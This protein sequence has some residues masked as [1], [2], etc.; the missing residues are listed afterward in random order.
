[1]KIGAFDS[2][3][4]GFSV[5]QPLLR[6]IPDLSIVYVADTAHV[7]YSGKTPE[8]LQILIRKILRFFLDSK[9]EAVIFACN[10]SSALVLPQILP[11]SFVPFFGVIEPG[12]QMALTITKGKGIG[13]AANEVT[14]KSGTFKKMIHEKNPTIPVFEQSCPELVSLVEKGETSSPKAS[15]IVKEY[16]KPLQGKIDTLILGCTHFPFLRKQFEESLPD[17]AVIDPAY[18]LAQHFMKYFNDHQGDLNSKESPKKHDLFTTA[19]SPHVEEW[20]KKVLGW[21]LTA[22]LLDLTRINPWVPEEVSS[23]EITS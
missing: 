19:Q 14:A 5:L 10:T 4:G 1:M 11:Y 16:M 6:E 23:Y 22:K 13:I 9:V 20:A 15:S 21:D 8:E 12:I 3:I 17:C 2:G 18:P 7:P